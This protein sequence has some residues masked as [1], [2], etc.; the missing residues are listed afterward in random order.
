MK[1]SVPSSQ[2]PLATL[3]LTWTRHRI[4]T[5]R[6]AYRQ[7]LGACDIG[8][9]A[10]DDKNNLIQMALSEYWW[11]LLVDYAKIH[12]V[13]QNDDLQERKEAV[14]QIRINLRNLPGKD[15]EQ[16]SKELL[17]F[18]K[19]EDSDVRGRAA[20]VLGVHSTQ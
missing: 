6:Q 20:N 8:G 3:P 4:H 17:A 7:R 1:S 15:K 14:D 13:A 5:G 10:A 2:V 9:K 16:A 11:L 18:T 19:E 12:G